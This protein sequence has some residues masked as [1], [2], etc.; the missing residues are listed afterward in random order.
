MDKSLFISMSGAQNASRQ[1]EIITNNLA[2]VNTTGFRA[3]STYLE[4]HQV[5]KTGNQSRVYA[6]LNTTY[7]DFKQGAILSTDRDL[8]VAL[9]GDGFIAVQSKSGQE[10]YTRIGNLQVKNGM[11]TTQNGNLVI[12]SSGPI[13]IPD[14]QRLN[15]APDGTVSALFVGETELTPIDK[16]KLT[17]PKLNELKKGDDGL[18]YFNEQGIAQA[19][20]NVTIMSGSLEASNVNAIETMTQLIDLTRN[21]QIHTNFMKTIMDNTAKANQLLD[22]VR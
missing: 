19:D 22:L 5:A 7:T 6:K 16:I 2:N 9:N 4:Q 17:N 21:Y 13:A 11:L 1:L 15:I 10:A 8:D 20:P 14:A 18:F 12:G 3:D